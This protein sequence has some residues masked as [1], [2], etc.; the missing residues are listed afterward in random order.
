MLG[1]FKT[2]NVRNVKLH[3][4]IM[5]HITTTIRYDVLELVYWNL[6]PKI[7]Q[8]SSL[9]FRF[10]A[11]GAVLRFAPAK[12][13]FQVDHLGPRAVQRSRSSSIRSA[14]SNK[15]DASAFVP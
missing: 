4:Q 15:P 12:P 1:T 3:F 10:S 5:E 6:L 9:D 8:K 2:G 14:G 13:L 7:P 11:V